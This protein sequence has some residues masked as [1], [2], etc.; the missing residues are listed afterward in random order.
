MF[1]LLQNFSRSS[2][3]AL[4]LSVSNIFSIIMASAF[5]RVILLNSFDI[6]GPVLWTMLENYHCLFPETHFEDHIFKW[7]PS[8]KNYV[9]WLCQACEKHNYGGFGKFFDTVACNTLTVQPPTLDVGSWRT[10]IRFLW[11]FACAKHSSNCSLTLNIDPPSATSVLS[12]AWYSLTAS[13]ICKLVSPDIHFDHWLFTLTQGF[14]IMWQD[15][16]APPTPSEKVFQ[17]VGKYN[18]IFLLQN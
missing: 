16:D 2:R 12:E 18:V 5:E 6:S 9:L 4:S 13:M 10:K 15:E 7:L 11:S 8:K 17:Y 3:R 14:S 1:F